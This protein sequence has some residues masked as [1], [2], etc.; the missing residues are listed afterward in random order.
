MGS[1]PTPA[2]VCSEQDVKG[3][4]TSV[5]E[6]A[7]ACAG[8]I[9]RRCPAVWRTRANP[10]YVSLDL[11]RTKPRPDKKISQY[12]A[13]AGHAR[14]GLLHV[15][16]RSLSPD[17]NLHKART[18]RQRRASPDE[19]NC[20]E[21]ILEFPGTDL[22]LDV[23]LA[24]P[25]ES[26]VSQAGNTT[27]IASAAGAAATDFSACYARELSSLV[28][29]VMSLGADAHRAADVAQSAFA[30][31][32][33]VWDRIEHPTAWLRRVAGR[34]LERNTAMRINTR[35]KL[36]VVAGLLGIAALFGSAAST[37]V[38]ATLAGMPNEA[39]HVAAMS[40]QDTPHEGM[41]NEG[42]PNE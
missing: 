27:E 38:G 21:T 24:Q 20:V 1:N 4:T 22:A 12:F 5:A 39:V 15:S 6:G 13:H 35:S 32:F 14:P 8:G 16:N 40:P 23:P 34:L 9:G 7:V 25:P 3:V 42:M 11:L 36:T 33:A 17:R 18:Y 29:F 28:W 19:V 30:E 31:A 41:P 26:L 10:S 2:P 37:A